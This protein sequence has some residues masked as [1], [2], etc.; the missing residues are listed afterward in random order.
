MHGRLG[1]R[2]N[3]LAAGWRDLG[4]RLIR[5]IRGTATSATAISITSG[6]CTEWSASTLPKTIGSPT[7][8]W[9]RLRGLDFLSELNLDRL[10]R[11]RHAQS[12]SHIRLPLTDACLVHLQALP[13][14]E[15]LSLAGNLITDQGLSQIAAMTN[16]K[17]LDLE[18][19][20]GQRCRSGPPRGDEEPREGQSGCDPSHQGG[21]REAPDG[22][23]GPVDRVRYRT[24]G[25]ARSQAAP[26]S[27]P[28]ERKPRRN[29]RICRR[30]P[31]TYPP[32]P[33]FR[34]GRPGPRMPSCW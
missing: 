34:S 7:R 4:D 23:A 17:V 33:A 13:R 21:Y 32:C 8:G 27:R 22:Q 26:R 19:H 16:L 30:R 20:R 11:F 25:G 15:N 14:L 5:G 28:N 18:R 1:H 2:S 29:L 31:S 10:N 9:P 12:S 3:E 6:S 24:G